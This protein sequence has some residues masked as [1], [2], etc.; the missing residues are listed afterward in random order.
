MEDRG[1]RAF[2][3]GPGFAAGN[4]PWAGGPQWR[5]E[6]LP[7]CK[8]EQQ[9]QFITERGRRPSQGLPHREGALT[10]HRP[11]ASPSASP[12][13]AWTAC[14]QI[15]PESPSP[16]VLRAWQ[17]GSQRRGRRSG[18]RPPRRSGAALQPGGRAPPGAEE[19]AL[20]PKRA[21]R[22]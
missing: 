7:S 9:L 6:A 22:K 2:S 5:S 3:E 15:S 19:H 16:T 14:F 21:P 20:K 1:T 13:E 8:K 12:R 4:A 18:A 17:G 10:K 11:E